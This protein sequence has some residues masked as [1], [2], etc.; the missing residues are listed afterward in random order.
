MRPDEVRPDAARD[1]LDVRLAEYFRVLSS[2]SRVQILRI[3][4]QG[5]AGAGELS[6]SLS[7]SPSSVSHQLRLL[8]AYG[9]VRMRRTGAKLQYSL[10]SESVRSML[11]TSMECA[12]AGVCP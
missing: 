1:G 7:L 11:K 6:R 3:L 8:Q 2:A 4:L 12:A 5:E 10:A 9:L